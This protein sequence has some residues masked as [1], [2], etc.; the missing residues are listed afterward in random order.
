MKNRIENFQD[1]SRNPLEEKV[2]ASDGSE[3]SI[4]KPQTH[5]FSQK[6]DSVIWKAFRLK[7]EGAFSYIYDHYFDVLFNYGCQF[8]KDRGL[9]EDILQDFFLDLR[10]KRHQL[11]EVLNIRAYLLKSFRRRVFRHLKKKNLFISSSSVEGEFNISFHQDIQFI[12]TQFQLEQRKQISSLLKNLTPRERE[13]IYHFFYENLDYK[14]TAQ[15]MEL[16][17]AKTSR[18][19]IYKAISGLKKKKHLFP[20]WLRFVLLLWN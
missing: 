19:L 13:A 12:N 7:H 3:G 11:G 15:I 8:T 20:D 9:V 2:D 4:E 14:S 1:N 18:N 10:I 17:G 6:E 5:S 16:S